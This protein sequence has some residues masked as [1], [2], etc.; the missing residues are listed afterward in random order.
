MGEGGIKGECC[1]EWIQERFILYIVRTFVNS[2]MYS[3][4]AQQ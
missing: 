2:T 1:M 4:P 3:Y